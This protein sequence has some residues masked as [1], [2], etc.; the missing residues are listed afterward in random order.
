MTRELISNYLCAVKMTKN[1]CM[2]IANKISD[3]LL[4]ILQKGLNIVE[5]KIIKAI[6]L[7]F[8]ILHIYLKLHE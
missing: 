6:I 5:T 1:F 8:Y 4:S 2:K 3:E 7:C